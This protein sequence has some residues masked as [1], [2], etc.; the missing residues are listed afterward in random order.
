MACSTAAMRRHSLCGS[1][2][3]GSPTAAWPALVTV[4]T[5]NQSL[6]EGY[7]S[8]REAVSEPEGDRRPLITRSRVLLQRFV[9]GCESVAVSAPPV[10]NV[11]VCE[12]THDPLHVVGASI[13]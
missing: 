12:N 13:R 4:L 10:V 6:P 11:F 7:R 2:T 9:Q 1:G 5:L 8:A 3:P